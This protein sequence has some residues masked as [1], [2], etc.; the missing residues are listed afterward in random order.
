MKFRKQFIVGFLILAL[1]VPVVSFVSLS[2]QKSLSIRVGE[3]ICP[4]QPEKIKQ[5]PI[6]AYVQSGQ[7]LESGQL[8]GLSGDSV[9]YD[10]NQWLRNGQPLTSPLL[11]SLAAQGN[12]QQ[13]GITVPADSVLVFHEDDRELTTLFGPV[14]ADKLM[15][16][17]Q[18]F[19]DCD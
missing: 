17:D 18:V 9:T 10:G 5:I 11:D 4:L 15:P 2:Y 19:V 13:A 12:V 14:L 6:E 1:I 16:T 8:I 3:E 7:S